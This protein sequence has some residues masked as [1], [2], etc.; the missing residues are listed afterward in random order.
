MG[1]S[2]VPTT[3]AAL[4]PFSVILALIGNNQGNLYLPRWLIC[5]VVYFGA[6]EWWILKHPVFLTKNHIVNNF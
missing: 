6:M 4:G 2:G 3:T 1:P 5:T